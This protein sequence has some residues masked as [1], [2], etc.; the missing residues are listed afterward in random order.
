MAQTTFNPINQ[1]LADYRPLTMYA[2]DANIYLCINA[3]RQSSYAV[4]PNG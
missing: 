3:Y 2:F 4:W 1:H